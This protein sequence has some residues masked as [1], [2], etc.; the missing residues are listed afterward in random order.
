MDEMLEAEIWSIA[1]IDQGNA[2]LLRPLGSNMVVPVFIGHLEVQAILLGLGEVKAKR[3]LTCDVFLDLAHQ[4]GLTLFRVEIHEIR[5][6]TFHARMLFF[7]REFSE[8]KPLVLD[9]RPSDAIALAV[10]EKCAVYLAPQVLDQ[11][12][13]PAEI[14][15]EETGAQDLNS[16]RYE[17]QDESPKD[18]NTPLTAKRR[19]LQ[20]ELEESVAA[21]AYERAAEIRDLL[22]LLDQEIEQERRGKEAP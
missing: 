19:R 16:S 7:G 2:V 18:E 6:D 17:P 5:D 4:L 12:G 10:R 13:I 20:A 21:E 11:T 8:A 15:I 3:P 22:I 14:F 9:S 1:R